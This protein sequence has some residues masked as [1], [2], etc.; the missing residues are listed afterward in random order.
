MRK[1][2]N[3]VVAVVISVAL[4]IS[5]PVEL[6]AVE[7]NDINA[8]FPL[9]EDRVVT[10]EFEDERIDGDYGIGNPYKHATKT[11]TYDVY[12]ENGNTHSETNKAT[13]WDCVW[14][15]NYW[16]DCE[17]IS[18]TK[19]P[20]KWR[21]L[22]VKGNDALVMADMGLDTQPYNTT[23]TSTTWKDCTLRSWLNNDFYNNA[24]SSQNKSAIIST[25]L[26]NDDNPY[27]GTEGGENTT[28]NVF[29]LSIADSQNADYGFDSTRY[30]TSYY[31]NSYDPGRRVKPTTFAKARGAYFCN[32]SG[33]YANNGW[34]WLRSPGSHT[35]SAA[36]V[37]DLGR[38]Y[39]IGYIVSSV[40]GS[41]RP[42]LHLNLSSSCWSPAGTVCSDG[43]VDET[44]PTGQGGSSSGEES[45]VN[46]SG[47]WIKE[48]DTH[49]RYKRDGEILKNGE[50][51]LV[52]VDNDTF[53]TV[54]I[55]NWYFDENG[56]VVTGVHNDYYFNDPD[57][58][59]KDLPYGIRVNT[60]SVKDMLLNDSAYEVLGDYNEI[61][62]WNKTLDAP[63]VFEM[64][65]VHIWD[66]YK[67]YY[68][69]V[70]TYDLEKGGDFYDEIV[71]K[72]MNDEVKSR[73][74]LMKIVD[75][76]FSTAVYDVSDE[77]AYK[78]VEFSL[79][80]LFNKLGPA[81]EK[82]LSE[83]GKNVASGDFSEQYKYVL[84]MTG[85]NKTNMSKVIGQSIS[86][87][88]DYIEF[89]P[90]VLK[91]FKDHTQNLEFLRSLRN[92][93]D[94]GSVL[95][96][97]VDDVET[98]Y[99]DQ[100]YNTLSDYLIMTLNQK[101]GWYNVLN[102]TDL[103]TDFPMK[104]GDKMEDNIN[105]IRFV[106]NTVTSEY[107][108]SAG[109]KFMDFIIKID[110]RIETA[111]AL[112]CS[113]ELSRNVHNSLADVERKIKYGLNSYED[114]VLYQNLF[115]VDKEIRAYQYKNMKDYY[116]SYA[117]AVSGSASEK[118][119]YCEK[120]YRKLKDMNAWNY[121]HYKSGESPS[122]Y[123]DEDTKTFRES[124]GVLYRNNWLLYNGNVFRTD[125]DGR[126][127]D[128]LRELDNN[129]Y[130]FSKGNAE[131]NA[132][133]DPVGTLQ[134]E[135]VILLNG[136][137]DEYFAGT[138]GKLQRNGWSYV[139]G[140]FRYYGADGKRDY[141][142]SSNEGRKFAKELFD[143]YAPNYWRTSINCPV[144]IVVFDKNGKEIASI[145]NEDCINRI[146]DDVVAY[147]D[148]NGQKL[149]GLPSKGEY[150]LRITVREEGTMDCSAATITGNG[151]DIG[152]KIDYRNL[153]IEPGDIYYGTVAGD[154][155]HLSKDGIE[156][157]VSEIQ[158]GLKPEE[159]HVQSD[160][161]GSA[162]G[163]GFVIHGDFVK[164][165]AKPDE[166]YIFDGWYN[167]SG[168]KVSAD[169]IY[170]FAVLE[171]QIYT[172]KFSSADSISKMAGN[173]YNVQI[174]KTGYKV[175]YTSSV[176]YNGVK[177][178]QKGGKAS[179][180]KAADIE[181]KLYDPNGKELSASDYK[182]TF[183]NN[184]DASGTKKP[185]FTVKLKGKVDK[186]IKQAFK[187][188]K[189][190]FTI[191]PCDLG[192]LKLSNYNVQEKNGELK[193]SGLSYVNET[194]KKIALK[195]V[196][197]S[198]KGDFKIEG[199]DPSKYVIRG[200][201]NYCGTIAVSK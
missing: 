127:L 165:M 73:D 119:D 184:K 80:K 53:R 55:G 102:G 96:K 140:E 50:Y 201:N 22:S 70:L 174:G 95:N 190:E 166:G 186:S 149:F 65:F 189:M 129:L 110:S 27:Y 123:Y 136:G 180:T 193:I 144:D 34:W 169:E 15:G 175:K 32:T 153:E 97:A 56:Y 137:A 5:M 93:T 89:C 141:T 164:L 170:R 81:I 179:K 60:K 3:K 117:L 183:K 111:D 191:M 158:H 61:D 69:A 17:D 29:L 176:S 168:I 122:I 7:E 112:L 194:G 100:L 74:L 198:G 59:I 79:D 199:S 151:N 46:R 44:A 23:Y 51:E 132:D 101:N 31:Y 86:L 171:S 154:D 160:Q 58:N 134:K 161:G 10:D 87:I 156:E 42:A 77:K 159:I 94:E 150:L 72:Y 21:V 20:I 182:V 54:Y 75:E 41:V 16:Q 84:N 115:Y 78:I 64:S 43:T 130:Y 67:A 178:M 33:E 146:S 62:A 124:S 8:D 71:N 121:M 4:S 173:T 76:R 88:T 98:Y 6:L 104:S 147:I 106:F 163:G 195:Q 83:D 145:V 68:S 113:M 107:K 30:N 128:G 105:L 92:V 35:T 52:W 1:S 162:A 125:N 142:R 57:T 45:N 109:K 12:N 126:P 200:I 36:N 108:L 197:K 143:K 37:N 9:E 167:E 155:F 40:H 196:G 26:V 187:D 49:Y 13:V 14:F 24:F 47:E 116:S 185:Y 139:E 39:E 157:Y 19:T 188:T 11:V 66:W 48:D 25:T 28:D 120:E 90:E 135:K 138:N 114:Y 152:S 181:V 192:K 148:D 85:K 118:S 63:T 177:H 172:A 18:G 38:V 2:I 103:I 99:E 91:C 131:T 133:N 82:K